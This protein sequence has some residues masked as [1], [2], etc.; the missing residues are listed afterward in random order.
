MLLRHVMWCHVMWSCDVL[1]CVVCDVVCCDIATTTTQ[2][3]SRSCLSQPAVAEVNLLDMT[4]SQEAR[5]AA[6]RAR[7]EEEEGSDTGPDALLPVAQALTYMYLSPPA[8][9]ALT[10][11]LSAVPGL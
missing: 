9:P 11:S 3:L 6:E 7:R 2:R 4:R 8:T 10:H 5:V 1:S